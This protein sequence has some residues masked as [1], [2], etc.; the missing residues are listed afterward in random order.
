MELKRRS[1]AKTFSYRV[2]GMF[3]TGGIVWILTGKPFFAVQVGIID[4]L[5]KLVGYYVHERI[6]SNIRFGVV[7][8]PEYEI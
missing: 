6:W 1:I 8:P 3:V 7:K 2:M 4:T 5:V